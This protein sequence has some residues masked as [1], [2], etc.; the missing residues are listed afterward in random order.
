MKLQ[1]YEKAEALMSESANEFMFDDT[2]EM[3]EF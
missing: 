3:K 1:E 2:Q